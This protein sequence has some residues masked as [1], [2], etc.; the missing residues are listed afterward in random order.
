MPGVTSGV[1]PGVRMSALRAWDSSLLSA[2]SATRPWRPYHCVCQLYHCA[3]WNFL[4]SALRDRTQHPLRCHP[5]HAQPYPTTPQC[6]CPDMPRRRWQ[7][8]KQA[9]AWQHT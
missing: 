1:A 3:V 8:M 7:V 4:R 2:L 9:R 5:G 6:I